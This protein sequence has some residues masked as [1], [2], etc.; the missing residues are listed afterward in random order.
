MRQR[1]WLELI[2]DYDLQIHYH[3]G[4]AN[5]VA[6]ALSRKNMGD[7]ANLFTEQKELVSELDKMSV[8]FKIHGQETVLAAVMAQ[9]TL[10]EEIKSHQME[11]DILKK[12][13]DELETKPKSWF[14]LV[15]SILKFQNRICVP[16]VLELKWK[17]MEETH[18]SRFSMHPGKW[19]PKYLA[20]KQ[21]RCFDDKMMQLNIS[22]CSSAALRGLEL[23]TGLFAFQ[24]IKAATNN[25]DDNNKIG[26]GGFR[27]V[28]KG[29]L[30]DGTVIA[31][32][33]L[34]SKSKQGNRE[35]VNEIGTILGLQ[36]PN[37]VRLYGCCIE[38]NQLL[39]V[40]EYM[41]NNSLARALFGEC[42]LKL[43]W[44]TRLSICIGIA[45][46]LAFL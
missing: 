28:Y 30:L 24:Q 7:L 10:L 31:V 37:L 19:A 44:P 3:P 43:D 32:K 34:S 27:S 13:C 14:S 8:E 29:I 6:D 35:F 33:Q 46:G 45:R 36:H 38:G 12:V 11:D 39:L 20:K 26:E 23:K 9:P 17:L 18:A 40:Y 5:T 22:T 41:E 1:Q 25:F 42:Q 21:S 15:D 16:N 2:K 4:K